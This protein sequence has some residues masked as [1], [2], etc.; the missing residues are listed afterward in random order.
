MEVP[1]GQ[2]VYHI[3]VGILSVALVA[4]TILT[5]HGDF[6]PDLLGLIVPLATKPHS[7]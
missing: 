6:H 4:F 1:F 7:G 2:Y 5:F 3:N